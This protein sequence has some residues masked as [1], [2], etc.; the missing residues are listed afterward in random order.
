MDV[1]SWPGTVVWYVIGVATLRALVR[2]GDKTSGDARSWYMISGDAKSWVLD[3]SAYI[4]CVLLS[5]VMST[6]AYV[7][8]ES[9]TQADRAQSSRVPVPLPDDPYVAIRQAWL[10]DTK[11]EPEEAPS[12]AEEL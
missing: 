6:P 12:E 7:D 1:R 4:H 5:K 2:A 8:S 3:C 11:S 10:V 9:I